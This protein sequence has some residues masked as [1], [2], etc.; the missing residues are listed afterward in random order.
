MI[1]IDVLL[2][3]KVRPMGTKPSGERKP[4]KRRRRR[5]CSNCPW[6]S[7]QGRPHA[8]AHLE[9]GRQCYNAVLSAGQRRLR[10]MRAEPAQA[11][12]LAPSPGHTPRSAGLPSRP[13]GSAMAFPSTPFTSL[14]K[15]YG[16]VAGRAPGCRAG[17]DARHSRIPRAQSRLRG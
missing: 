13:C 6:S 16:S 3:G 10:Q 5:F 4:S 7:R 12:R 11:G 1:G 17:P 2:P 14:R 15:S 8:C 9:A